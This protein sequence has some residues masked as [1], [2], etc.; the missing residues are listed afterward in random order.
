MPDYAISVFI[1]F[2]VVILAGA[3]GGFLAAERGLNVVVWF[4]ISALVPPFILLFFFIK[5][6]RESE[7]MLRKCARCGELINWQ[8]AACNCC[9]SHQPA[10]K[11]SLKIS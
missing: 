4:T 3:I 10:V 11:R 5:P 2:T 8:A 1:L 6:L 9:Q 7:A